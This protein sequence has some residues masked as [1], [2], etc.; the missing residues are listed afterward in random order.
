MLI[1]YYSLNSVAN[2]LKVV[3]CPSGRLTNHS[4]VVPANVLISSLQYTASDPIVSIIW[5]WNIVRWAS[6]SSTP[7]KVTFRPRDVVGNAIS[8][9]A[10]EDGMGRALDGMGGACSSTALSPACC[11]SLRSSSLVLRNSSLSPCDAAI[12]TLDAAT[13]SWRA[14]MVFMSCYMVT[15]SPPEGATPGGTADP[16]LVLLISLVKTLNQDCE[17]D[18]VDSNGSPWPS[19]LRLRIELPWS[20]N[21]SPTKTK[22][23]LTAVCTPTL[24]LV[25][26]Q[27]NTKCIK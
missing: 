18:L 3:M 13:V 12:S 7:V 2:W 6:G 11:K 16:C 5:V 14:R 25:L 23:A 1:R 4:N 9:I 10:W 20:K 19:Y 24:K 21:L 22:G 27:R 15:L 17:W 8:I 26:G